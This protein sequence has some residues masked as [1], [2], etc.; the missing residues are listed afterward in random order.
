MAEELRRRLRCGEIAAGARLPSIQQLAASFDVAPVTARR[1]LALLEEEDMVRV[2]H[3]RGTF[4]SRPP[5]WDVSESLPGFMPQAGRTRFWKV[6]L[7]R[8]ESGAR[9]EEARAALG[10]DKREQMELAVRLRRLRGTAAVLQYSYLPHSLKR[11]LQR[12]GSGESLYAEIRRST[13]RAPHRSLEELKIA[14]AEP[15]EA[16]LLEIAPG[17]PLFR[18]RRL[19]LDDRGEPLVWDLAFLR[20][21]LCRVQL[22]TTGRSTRAAL[23]WTE[24]GL[25][26]GESND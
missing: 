1:A 11:V 23:S 7:I 4:A 25:P 21:D 14:A 26:E 19:T 6:E 2:E 18:G 22:E 5:D 13:G 17:T 15:A 16:E 10:L 24:S 3:G 12:I 9:D 8:I 20:G